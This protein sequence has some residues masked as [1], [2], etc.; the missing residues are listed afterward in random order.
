MRRRYHTGKVEAFASRVAIRE[1]VSL[2]GS[3]NRDISTYGILTV[4]KRT[5]VICG[6]VCA[7]KGVI[8]DLSN[9]NFY[10][11]TYVDCFFLWI[12]RRDKNKFCAK[13]YF[14]RKIDERDYTR[15]QIIILK[16]NTDDDIKY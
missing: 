14:L 9:R 8:K 2:R 1:L 6:S 11:C 15:N 13:Q 7:T 10:F 12:K 16:L 4:D 5:R 3:G